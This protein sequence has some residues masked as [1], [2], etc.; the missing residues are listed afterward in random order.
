MV[1]AVPSSGSVNCNGSGWR[2]S[3]SGS[4][5]VTE[6][7]PFGIAIADMVN[8]AR[9]DMRGEGFIP[10]QLVFTLELGIN[11]A[12]GLHFVESPLTYLEREDDG[13]RL[14]ELYAS[15][16]G[17][18]PG[19]LIIENVIMKA[20]CPTH[21]YRLSAFKEQGADPSKAEKGLRDVCWG[22]GFIRTKIYER[23][24]LKCGNFI[25]GPAVIESPDTTYVVPPHW[26]YTLDKY[27]NGILEVNQ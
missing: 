25:K 17:K 12:G 15:R 6:W 19:E 27:R 1:R 10:E 21:H 26:S 2:R 11:G 3:R 16:S 13:K 23:D 14:A 20:I 24:L 4:C 9:R 18:D 5:P 7:K 22:K 8:S